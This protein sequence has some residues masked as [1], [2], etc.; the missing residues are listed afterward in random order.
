MIGEDVRE[1]L[2]GIETSVE[3]QRRPVDV[4]AE[5]RYVAIDALVGDGETLSHVMK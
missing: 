1:L 4:D 5:R 2:H 3:S